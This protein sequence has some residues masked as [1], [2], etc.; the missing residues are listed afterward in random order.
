M[1]SASAARVTG[2]AR[3]TNS[4]SRWGSTPRRFAIRPRRSRRARPRSMKS[5]AARISSTSV[6]GDARD[7]HHEVQI[8]AE[9]VD[10]AGVAGDEGAA[11]LVAQVDVSQRGLG[12]PQEPGAVRGILL[13]AVEQA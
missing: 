7:R 11:L 3:S 9:L 12:L 4:R 6:A 2:P 10:P 13:E 5:A 8:A 1:A